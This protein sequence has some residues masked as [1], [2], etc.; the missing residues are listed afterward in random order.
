LSGGAGPGLQFRRN[1]QQCA[2]Q[3]EGKHNERFGFARPKTSTDKA[4][5]AACSAGKAWYR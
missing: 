5:P 1:S 4:L 2:D 3:S